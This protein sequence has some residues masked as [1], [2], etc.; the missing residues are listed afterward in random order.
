MALVLKNKNFIKIKINLINS[1]NKIKEN[2]VAELR[3]KLKYVPKLDL[4]S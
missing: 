2:H 3:N 4:L 1:G